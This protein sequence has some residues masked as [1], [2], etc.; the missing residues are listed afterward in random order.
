MLNPHNPPASMNDPQ[1]PAEEDHAPRTNAT[2]EKLT[3]AQKSAILMDVAQNKRSEK[4]QVQK[5]LDAKKKAALGIGKGKPVQELAAS[6]SSDSEPASSSR[7]AGSGVKAV[8]ALSPEKGGKAKDDSSAA[9]GGSGVKAALALKEQAS[10]KAKAGGGFKSAAGGKGKKGGGKK[11][12]GLLAKEEAEEEEEAPAAAE[13]L[14]AVLVETEADREAR[15]NR[16]EDEREAERERRY[17]EREEQRREIEWEIIQEERRVR[18]KERKKREKLLAEKK[19]QKAFRDAAYEGD[20]GVIR[21]TIKLWCDECFGEFGDGSNLIGAKVDAPDEHKHTALS[22]A[23]CGG[24]AAICR[25]LLEHGANVNAV[26]AQ[27]RTPLWRACFMD[28]RECVKLLLEHGADPRIASESHEAPES[29]SPA[30]ELKALL[31]GWD[32]AHT[33]KLLAEREK[34][35][36]KQ[37]QPPPPDPEDRDIGE[38]GYFLQIALQ[39]LADAVDSIT[40]DSDRTILVVDLGGKAITYFEYSDCNLCCYAR[41][42][43]IEPASLRKKLLGALRYGKPLVLDMLSMELDH[44]LI[45]AAFDAVMPGLFGKILTKKVLREEVYT[46]LINEDDGDDYKAAF[47]S[48]KALGHFQFIMISKLPVPPE[49]CAEGFFILRV[50]A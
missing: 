32:V 19:L 1:F 35:N 11:K 5:I 10:G 15:L 9:A 17:K 20:V 45:E 33:D 31:Q 23:A 44:N 30:D 16:E 38:A 37:W 47:F 39:R 46:Q 50:A 41:A 12:V 25:I 22:E 6:S 48:E 21:S 24:Q 43:E 36:A 42:A 8:L 18:E 34:R 49:W 3:F 29:V 2:G 7:A 40:K 14:T 27:H 26:N 13:S 4:E 28:K